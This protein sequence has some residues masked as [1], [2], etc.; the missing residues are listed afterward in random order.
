MNDWYFLVRVGMRGNFEA[1]LSRVRVARS[2]AGG[3]VWNK[4]DDGCRIDLKK[5]RETSDFIITNLTQRARTW[6][7]HFAFGVC[8][9]SSVHR[10]KSWMNR[11]AIPGL[12]WTSVTQRWM[13]QQTMQ[14]LLIYRVGQTQ[15]RPQEFLSGGCKAGDHSSNIFL[16]CVDAVLDTRSHCN[17]EG[18][19]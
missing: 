6:P 11:S 9:I 8:I 2:H 10:T 4:Q 19:F 13:L 7:P 14:Q 3:R 18:G 16:L 5:T 1:A 12:V 17:W 15:G